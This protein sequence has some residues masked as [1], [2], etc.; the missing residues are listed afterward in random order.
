[1]RDGSQVRFWH[2]LCWGDS[3]FKVTYPELYEISGNTDDYVAM[4]MSVDSS[5]L[6]WDL[7]FF[8]NIHD[9]ELESMTSF[10]D[11]IYSVTLEG[12][13]D[14]RLHWLRNAKR[15]YSVKSFYRCLSPSLSM[16]FPWKGIWK[17]KVPPRVAFSCGPL[18][19]TK[20]SLLIT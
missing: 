12:L 5:V 15:D 11:L 14:D 1:V 4:L 8:R 10:M 2:D 17:P 6:H 3:P 13:R 9:W 20:F 16:S 19:L 18:L 7:D